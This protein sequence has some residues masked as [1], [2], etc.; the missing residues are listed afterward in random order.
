[1]RELL[2]PPPLLSNPHPQTSSP[3]KLVLGSHGSRRSAKFLFYIHKGTRL[4][5]L[6]KLSSRSL[7]ASEYYLICLKVGP[8]Y[9][10]IKRTRLPKIV[11]SRLDLRFKGQEFGDLEILTFVDLEVPMLSYIS[12]VISKRAVKFCLT[13]GRI[14][15]S[16]T[17]MN[18]VH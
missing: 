7:I 1:M 13:H 4:F 17:F 2:R 18:C 8:I 5:P 15:I 14:Q 3:L 12:C 16:E 9:S 10:K 11:S 6:G